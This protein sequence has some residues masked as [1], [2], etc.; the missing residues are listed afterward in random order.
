[1]RVRK[2]G[3][4]LFAFVV[5]LSINA[6]VLWSSD[7]AP[8][9]SPDAALNM[10]KESNSCF[11]GGAMKHPN[12]DPDRRKQCTSGGQ[13]PFA[14]VLSCSDSRVPVEV[15]FD[16]GIGDIF[17]VRVAGNVAD[18]DET[19]SIEYGV[20]HL[21]TPVLVV[22][23][24]TRCGAVTAVAQGA[25]LHGCIP[26]LVENIEPA[27][28]KAKATHPELTG[29]ALVEEAVKANVWQAIDDVLKLSEAVRNRAKN[30]TV[31][32]VGAIYDIESGKVNWMGS[33]PEQEQLIAKYSAAG[34]SHGHGH[35]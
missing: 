32:I 10:L 20:D 18:T 25:K 21:G 15:L 1:M 2:T 12:A 26:A 19:G 5:I 22:L 6:P 13:H 23:G 29:D 7:A 11:T 17:V 28:A 31:K 30:G 3:L 34:S 35:K 9:M 27:V 24:H 16:S 8:V 4:F 14:T 33:H